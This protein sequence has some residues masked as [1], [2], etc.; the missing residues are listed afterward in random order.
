MARSV[1]CKGVDVVVLCLKYNR[2]AKS[3][4]V[5]GTSVIQRVLLYM[6]LI[7][8]QPEH[9]MNRQFIYEYRTQLT[10]CASQHRSATSDSI[11]LGSLEKQQMNDV[12]GQEIKIKS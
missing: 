10:M 12:V 5:S 2:I 4:P 6:M 8:T 3:R 9:R 1:E 7:V 11:I